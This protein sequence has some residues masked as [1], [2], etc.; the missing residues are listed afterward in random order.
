MFLDERSATLLKL[1]QHSSIPSMS[2]IEDQTGLTR[3]QIQYSLSKVNDWLEFKNYDPVQYKREIGYFL[4][5]K[6]GEDEISVKQTKRS[7]VFSEK[8]REQVIYLMILLSQELLS[9]FHFQSTTGVSRNTILNDLQRLKETAKENDLTIHYSKQAGYIITGNS[10]VKRFVIEQLLHEVLN[11]S[12]SQMITQCIWGGFED[13]IAAVHQQLE[14]IETQLEITFTDDRL[15]ELAYLFFSADQLI[16]KGEELEQEPS[17]IPFTETKEY[18]LIGEMIDTVAFQ[19][20]WSQTEKLYAT[21]HLVSMNRTKDRS[22]LRDDRVFHELLQRVTEEFER[23][24]FVHLQDKEQLCEQLYVHFKPAYYRVQ[25]GFPHVNPMM[26]RV[27]KIYPELQHLTRKSLR[28]LEKELGLQLPEDEVAYFTIYFGG[29]L[30]RQGTRLDDRKKA[31]VVCPHGIG[32]SNIL[33]YTLRELFPTILFLDVLSVRDT[34]AYPLDYDLVFSSVF[35]RTEA[36]LF[37]VPPILEERDKQKLNRQVMQEL[38]GYTV[39]DS[40]V[41]GLI[42][43]ISKYATINDSTQLEKELQATL[44]TQAAGTNTHAVKE[45]E[46]PVLG[47]LLTT[48]TLQLKSHSA[49]WQE[50]IQLA[51]SPLVELGTVEERYVTAMVE[52]I[53]KNGPYVVITPLVAIPHARPEEGVRSL[54]MSLLKL[55]QA[56]DFAPDKPVQL[57]IVLAAADSDSH[58]R[59]LIQLTNLLSEPANIQEMLQATDKDQ[60]L[61]IIHNYSKEE[62]E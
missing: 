16:S 54:S 17:W 62:T 31:I 19:S 36:N 27:S 4:L 33:N 55:E 11:G 13:R 29:W 51:A 15:H 5:D 23:L 52:S 50:A 24:T 14:N 6:I 12:N 49:T 3:R 57:I 34:A 20:Q 28:I 58:L 18:L 8:D 41:A 40:D 46:K 38:Y 26:E 22:P 43:L 30:Q 44:Y 1:L 35:M 59:A 61:E 25:Y 37:V 53:E 56:V 9:V 7:Y 45:A 32:V 2:E 48:Q 60:L 47:E 39:P 10:R 21:L 42:K